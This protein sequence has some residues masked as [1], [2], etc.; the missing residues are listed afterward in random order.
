[1][2]MKTCLQKGL[3]TEGRAHEKASCSPKSHCRGQGGNSKFPLFGT[4]FSEGVC[5]V[6]SFILMT[7]VQSFETIHH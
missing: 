5:I 3:Y 6:H 1:M 7:L 2:I 4:F